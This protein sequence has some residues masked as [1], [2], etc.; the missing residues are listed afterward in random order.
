[1][2]SSVIAHFFK[3][4]FKEYYR[5]KLVILIELISITTS[6]I[7]YFYTS[8]AFAN[9]FENQLNIMGMDY[10]S[11]MV[12]GDLILTL[13]FYLFEGSIHAIKR[14]KIEGTFL[15]LQLL[16][17]SYIKTLFI[18][19]FVGSLPSLFRSLIILA[20]YL[21]M[22][23]EHFYLTNFILISLTSLILFMPFAL[24]SL[25][26]FLFTGR[27]AFIFGQIST[28]IAIFSG[29]Y[30]PVTIL[31]AWIA[32]LS[33]NFNP[34]TLFLNHGRSLIWNNELH[35]KTPE[36]LSI[37]IMCLFLYLP[38]ILLIRY[39]IKQRY[40]NGPLSVFVGG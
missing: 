23:P 11:F 17:Q 31:P 29:S 2:L 39:A 7:I 10:F 38:G 19:I 13:P 3:L 9:S 18:F 20:L 40:K 1:M 8:K 4:L 5:G 22:S 35:P 30:F 25:S 33:S 24:I 6:L 34:F 15:T 27:G 14:A 26:L 36:G 37:I 12:I 16:H 28:L 32:N 21:F